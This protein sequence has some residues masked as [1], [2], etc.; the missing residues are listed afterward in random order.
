LDSVTDVTTIASPASGLVVYNT[1]TSGTSPKNVFSGFYYFNGTKWI[2]LSG[3]TGGNDWSL[4]GNAGTVSGSSF[5][6]TTDSINLD[7]RTNKAYIALKAKKEIGNWDGKY[8]I[9]LKKMTGF[10]AQEVEQAANE[11]EYDFSGV[12]APKNDDLYGLRY[13]EFVV[14]LVKAVQE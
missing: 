12:D 13:V 14:P 11:I 3:G 10:I 5:L 4:L 7:I 2:A 8:D 9:E 6:G 1:A